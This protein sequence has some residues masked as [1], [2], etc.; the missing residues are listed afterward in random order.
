M[1]V[2]LFIV[3]LLIGCI[4][5]PSE[6]NNSE[7]DSTIANKALVK[8]FDNSELQKHLSL[9]PRLLWKYL[10][11][12]NIYGVALSENA[13]YSVLGSWDG[14]VYCLNKKGDFIWKFKD[15]T[16]LE[17]NLSRNLF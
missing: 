3:F 17:K 7:S 14:G 8:T 11:N 10:T 9:Q 12:G 15:I 2:G 1:R 6:N 13:E 16:M 4:Q 5:F